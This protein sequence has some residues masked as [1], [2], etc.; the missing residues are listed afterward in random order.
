MSNWYYAVD[1]ASAGPVDDA[2]FRDLVSQ[3]AIGLSTLVWREGMAAW[4]PAGEL[5]E[6]QSML[7]AARQARMPAPPPA[8][9]I[10]NV[11]RRTVET[12]APTSGTMGV[13]IPLKNPMALAGY[14][15]GIF[16]LIPVVGL[17]LSVPAI[18][19]GILGLRARSR[20]PAIRGAAHGWIAVATGAIS[21]LLYGAFVIAM[22]IAR[23]QRSDY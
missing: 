16:S 8:P 23:S 20:N 17:L 18:V 14:Y 2:S 13:M 15:M 1:G 4:T 19:L 5:A 3:G 22:M 12:E 11:R 21:L 9:P 6:V 7:V 10:V